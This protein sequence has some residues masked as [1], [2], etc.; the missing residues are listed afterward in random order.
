MRYFLYL[1]F[2][3]G[4]ITPKHLIKQGDLLFQQLQCG[5]MCEAIEDA[6]DGYNHYRISHVGIVVDSAGKPY[7]LE[8]YGHVRLTPIDSFL[9][10]SLD[11]RGRPRVIVERLRRPYR[12]LIP[13]AIKYG[14]TLVG[15]PYDTVFSLAN[16]A[17]YCSE[18]IYYMFRY[19]YGKDFFPVHPMNFRSLADGHMPQ[20]WIDYFAAMGMKVPQDSL[21]CN[22]ADYSRSRYLKVLYILG[23]IDKNK[24]Y[25]RKS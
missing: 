14:K 1:L 8:A 17:Y 11:S 16:D 22:P 24:N 9:Y 2:V 18:L 15:K 25:G 23:R 10:R 19:S 7:V 3:L 12:N 21:G 20:V 13:K 5:P 4:L 6:T